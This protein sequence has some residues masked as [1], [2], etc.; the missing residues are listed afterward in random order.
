MTG[1]PGS[2]QTEIPSNEKNPSWDSQ[3]NKAR[4]RDWSGQG[5]LGAGG[6]GGG[7]VTQGNPKAATSSEPRAGERR[8][9]Q[10]LE[11]CP[12]HRGSVLTD[13]DGGRASKPKL[14]GEEQGF[15]LRGPATGSP[16]GSLSQLTEG[17][18]GNTICPPEM[19]LWHKDY[20]AL[21]KT[22]GPKDLGRN[23]HHP[24]N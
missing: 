18:Q 15:Q 8:A 9:A 5:R 12:R 16:R 7:G 3:G 23:F 1:R 17:L 20:F 10:G 21:K 6:G 24:L 19:S 2:R 22:Q 4:K 13:Q 14:Q 11:G